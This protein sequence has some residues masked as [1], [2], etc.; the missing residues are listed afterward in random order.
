MTEFEDTG[1]PIVIRL[2]GEAEQDR[3]MFFEAVDEAVSQ[4]RRVKVEL[5]PSSHDELGGFVK[6]MSIAEATVIDFSFVEKM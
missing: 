3:N 2:T 1:G 5:L 4:S 6:D